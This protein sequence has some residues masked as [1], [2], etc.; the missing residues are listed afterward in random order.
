[1]NER[2][3][4]EEKYIG[5]YKEMADYGRGSMSVE[6]LKDYLIQ[7]SGVTMIHVWF[8]SPVELLAKSRSTP[9]NPESVPNPNRMVIKH[10]E[11]QGGLGGD[12]KTQIQNKLLKLHT[13][14]ENYEAPEFTP[15]P[16]WK[17]KGMRVSPYLVKHVSGAHYLYLPNPVKKGTSTYSLENG[18]PIDVNEISRFF[19]AKS[20]GSNKQ[21]AAGLSAEDQIYPKFVKLD[22][23]TKIKIK[24]FDL[25]IEAN[26]M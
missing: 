11:Y 5:M 12:Y 3:Y 10:C 17:G 7:G 1:M 16:I 26:V 19:K 14:D 24:G 6:Q 23:I 20:S 22:H 8:D 13:D 2:R 9:E 4:I 15:E 25:D 21:A 18:E